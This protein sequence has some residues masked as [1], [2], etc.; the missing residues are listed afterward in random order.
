MKRVDFSYWMFSLGKTVIS[1]FGV[2]FL[3]GCG[4]GSLD[5]SEDLGNGYYYYSNSS[6]DRFIAPNVWD[7][8]TP[9][10]PSKVVRY[11]KQNGYIIAE[12]EIIKIGI[13]GSRVAT[14][15]FDYWI[16]DTSLPKVFGPMG[17]GEFEVK[18]K[19]LGVTLLF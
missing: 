5:Y 12:R 18:L 3:V 17:N 6:M 9:M 14:G 15:S 16:L 8:N 13:T 10:I 19:K 11:K 7:E 2:I 4:S 1:I